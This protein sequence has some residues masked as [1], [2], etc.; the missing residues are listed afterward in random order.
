MLDPNRVP[1]RDYVDSIVRQWNS[2]KHARHVTVPLPCACG[3]SLELDEPRD[4]YME[5]PKCHHKFLI[6]Y[7]QKVHIT[8]E[9]DGSVSTGGGVRLSKL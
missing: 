5:C 4:T 9:N 8:G 6:T 2:G 7:G 1:D 3:V